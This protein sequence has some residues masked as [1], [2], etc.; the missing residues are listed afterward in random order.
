MNDN[1]QIIEELIKEF[2]RLH[3]RENSLDE[4]KIISSWNSVVG[5]F[6]AS[7]TLDLRITKGI[8]YVK[9]DADSLRNELLYS[10]CILLKN[11]NSLV[12][13]DILKD[14]IIN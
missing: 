5:E 7:H 9:V 8:L 10:K 2:Y 6:I 11:L 14:I 13:S 1:T 4:M 12:K 3:H